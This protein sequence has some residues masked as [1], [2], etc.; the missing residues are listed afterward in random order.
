MDLQAMASSAMIDW[1][2]LVV[3]V[4]MVVWKGDSAVLKSELQGRSIL[5]GVLSIARSSRG[6]DCRSTRGRQ[7]PH[8]SPAL[9]EC[10]ES[11]QIL[12]E[13]SLLG[14]EKPQ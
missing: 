11:F 2:D 14:L 5:G 3:A 9:S 6:P 7:L 10:C 13:A 1:C 12:L 4:W 8:S